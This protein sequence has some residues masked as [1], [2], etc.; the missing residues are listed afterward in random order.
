L[1]GIAIAATIEGQRPLLI[2]VQALVTQS[3]YARRS[4]R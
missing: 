1:S 3:V 4:V 2:E